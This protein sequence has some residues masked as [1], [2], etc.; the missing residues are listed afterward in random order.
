MSA[1]TDTSQIR[2]F[3]RQIMGPGKR[4]KAFWMAYEDTQKENY[5]YLF[6]DVSPAGNAKHMLRSFIFPDEGPSVIYRLKV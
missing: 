3:G 4:A 1:L 5:L 6:V 2:N